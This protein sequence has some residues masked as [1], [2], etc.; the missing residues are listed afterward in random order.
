MFHRSLQENQKRGN[1]GAEWVSIPAARLIH[2]QNIQS[3]TMV[4]NNSV[5]SVTNQAQCAEMCCFFDRPSSSGRLP[6]L[7]TGISFKK[8]IFSCFLQQIHCIFKHKSLW[9]FPESSCI[10]ILNFFRYPRREVQGIEQTRPGSEIPARYSSVGVHS[11]PA[12]QTNGYRHHHH[13][14]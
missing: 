7:G 2:F 4:Q 1:G 9:S 3:L 10:L 14:L 12:G 6:G 11:G 8:I 13:R 5:I